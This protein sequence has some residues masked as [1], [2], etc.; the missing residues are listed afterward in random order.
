MLLKPLLGWSAKAEPATV[1]VG[2]IVEGDSLI[3]VRFVGV[4]SCQALWWWERQVRALLWPLFPQS[5]WAHPA[6][7]L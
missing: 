1:V 2:T 6:T 5:A 4:G 7:V 3:P